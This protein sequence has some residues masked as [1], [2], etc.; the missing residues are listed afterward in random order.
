MTNVVPFDPNLLAYLDMAVRVS[1]E[2]YKTYPS[3]VYDKRR[4]AAESMARHAVAYSLRKHVMVRGLEVFI[5]D[6]VP[7]ERISYPMIGYLLGCDHSGFV[8]GVKCLTDD[9]AEIIDGKVWAKY[10]P[11]I[12]VL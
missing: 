3:R 1:C 10:R 6:Q 9:E 8:H 7:G 2:H 5:V 12:N 4:S 11:Y